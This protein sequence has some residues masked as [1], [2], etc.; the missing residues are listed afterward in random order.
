LQILEYHL[1]RNLLDRLTLQV[2]PKPSS[3]LPACRNSTIAD[4]GPMCEVSLA[5]PDWEK[6]LLIQLAAD[7]SYRPLTALGLAGVGSSAVT[8]F[9]AADGERLL[10]LEGKRTEPSE[11]GGAESLN[12]GSADGLERTPRLDKHET[13]D[14][15]ADAS[16]DAAG[17]E[18]G[19]KAI[20]ER[21]EEQVE[22]FP[23]GF[24]KLADKRVRKEELGAN[25]RAWKRAAK[26]NLNDDIPVARPIPR[27]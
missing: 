20:K 12:G 27:R 15:N 9:S 18:E 1:K 7:V 25:L 13:L 23:G 4:G 21:F 17:L 19:V 24:A 5:L 3:T 8:S 11:R 2:L 26:T 22:G 6:N 16:E 14:L 10:G